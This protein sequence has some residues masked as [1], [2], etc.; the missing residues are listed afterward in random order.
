MSFSFISSFDKGA[1]QTIFTACAPLC[2]A[3]FCTTAT[4]DVQYGAAG[5]SV[6]KGISLPW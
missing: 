6:C 4:D 1:V 2:P 5:L 3:I